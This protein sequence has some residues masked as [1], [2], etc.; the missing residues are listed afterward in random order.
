MPVPEMRNMRNRDCKEWMRA[1]TPMRRVALG[2]VA[3]AVALFPPQATAQMTTTTV[4]GTVYRADGTA[5]SGTLLVSWSAFTTP[6]NQAVAA[7]NMSTT[8]GADGFV[9]LN[10]TPNAAALP[11]GSYYTAVYHLSD[12]TVNQEYWV[13]PTSA[14]ASIAS[15][16]AQLQPSTVAVQAVSKS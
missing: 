11:T 5:A 13:V 14:S 10:L 4:Q 3:I 16:R 8:I 7:G 1:L 15:V 6:Q 12:G 9:S 2:L